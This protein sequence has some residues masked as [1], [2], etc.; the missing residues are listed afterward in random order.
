MKRLLL[1][2]I[3]LLAAPPVFAWTVIG[4]G[5]TSGATPIF[6]ETFEATG[7]DNAVW[8]ETNTPLPDYTTGP[9]CGA[10][11]LAMGSGDVIKSSDQSSF[12][13]AKIVLNFGASL[14]NG[15]DSY[16]FQFFGTG[17]STAVAKVALDPTDYLQLV[18]GGTTVVDTTFLIQTNTQYIVWLDY[19]KGTGSNAYGAIYIAV[20]TGNDC[21]EDKPAS[22]IVTTSTANATLDAMVLW[23]GHSNATSPAILYDNLE[24]LQ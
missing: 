14:T 3:L 2:V 16:L 12:T 5:V 19:T 20:D 15:S 22:P 23:V 7:Y 13:S 21:V 11:S 9:L 1:T 24:I 17:G 18:V 10:Q 4:S 8:T 6:L